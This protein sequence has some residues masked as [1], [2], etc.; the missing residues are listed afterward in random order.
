MIDYIKEGF[1]LTHKNWQLILIQITVMFIIFIGFIVFVGVPLAIAFVYFGVDLTSIKDATNIL[2]DPMK[3]FSRYSSGLAIFIIAALTVYICLASIL[4]MFAF[5]GT[6][7]VLRNSSLDKEYKFSL[8]SFLKEG[9]GLFLSIIGFAVI[10]LLAFITI[11]FILGI[12]T[13]VGFSVVNEYGKGGTFFVLFISYFLAM[14]LIISGIII[15]LCVLALFAYAITILA[16]EKTGPLT[17]FRKSFSFMKDKPRAILFYLVL[18]GGYMLTN[19]SLI[20]LNYPF[21][22]I[23]I[24]GFFINI[25]YQMFSYILLNYLVIVVSSSLISFYIKTM[26]YPVRS[27]AYEI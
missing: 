14:L 6:L 5:G 24:I 13:G 2:K 1:R 25:P 22:L 8:L 4:S 3:F 10:I 26:G 21:T 9:K 18:L 19:F 7:G 16:V 11:S 27:G 12:L 20:L 15:S 23:P 17:A